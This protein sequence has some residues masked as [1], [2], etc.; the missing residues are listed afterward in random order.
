M[1]QLVKIK[2]IL[3]VVLIVTSTGFGFAQTDSVSNYELEEFIVLGTKETE[4]IV[5]LAN[6]QK[7]FII[8]GRKSEVISIQ[9]MPA[10]LAEK[11][12]RQLFAKIPSGMVYDMDGSGNQ[13]NFSVRGLDAHR[14]W[15]F[16]VRQNG[17]IIN[18][19]MY[20]Y[21]ASHYS[22]P[23]EAVDRIEL[24]RGTA[25]LQ[26]GQQFGG[27]L[28][29]VLKSADT[30]KEFSFENLTS[31]GSFGLFA[32]YN[33]IGGKVDKFTYHAYYQLRKSNGYRENAR[34]DSDAQHVGLTYDVNEKLKISGQ[35]SRSYYM[36]KI[37][38]PLT[39]QQFEENPRQSTRKRNFYS[40]EMYIPSL[41][42]DWQISPETR[43]EWIGSGAFGE[44]S[45]VTFDAFANVPDVIDPATNEFAPRNVDIDRYNSRTT[46][47]RILHEY[48]LGQVKSYFSGYVRYFNNMFGR[49]QRGLGTTGSDFN[50]TVSNGFARDIQLHSESIALA[51]ENQFNISQK[52]SISPGIRYEYGN[53]EM[54]GRI[55]YLEESKVPKT[56]PYNFFSLGAHTAYFINSH[57]KLYGGISQAV[58]QV[59]FQDLIPSSPLATINENLTN[60]VGYNAEVGWENVWED[61][62]KYNLTFFRTYISNRI[63]NILV[64]EDG[65]PLIGKSNIGHSK[66]DGIELY[67]D[68]KILFSDQ[69]LLSFYTASSYLNAR[70]IS[71]NVSNGES[72]QEIAGNRIEAVPTW[73]SR[74][75][76]T[77]TVRNLKVALQHQFV[78]KSFADALN[79]R[80]PAASGAVGLVPQYHV[81]DL[82]VA[83]SFWEKFVLRAGINNMLNTQYF[84]KRPQM[85]PGPGIWSSDSRGF[86]V[87]I[88]TKI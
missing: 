54:F 76:L 28:N 11:I 59:L 41:S 29:Y 48:H 62:V 22:M 88:G 85:Y 72:N 77:L 15:E 38:G 34:S 42:L 45:S 1:K 37:P 51:V 56:I 13:V 84:T 78:G 31:T 64:E 53:S 63:G 32:T 50:L 25:A 52:F 74:N 35:L 14:S 10:N 6:I 36:Y 20:G 75:G 4:V 44:R 12:G 71:G 81:W 24:V 7:T 16:N 47:A 73:I 3:T 65:Q 61:R 2:K 82:N 87:S 8:G 19:D 58:R 21:P 26:Y 67:L 60:S 57:S 5:P 27:M 39:D 55:A 86:V 66:T 23:M 69:F 18:T 70:Y 83:F 40:P 68:W 17:T 33:S 80:N 46:E 79:T 43:F 49:K 30:A 9:D